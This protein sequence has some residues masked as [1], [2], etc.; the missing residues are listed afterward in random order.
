MEPLRKSS[1]LPP[2]AD[3][4]LLIKA[5]LLLEAI[6]L[7]LLLLP[8]RTS[9]RL[10]TRVAGWPVGPWHAGYHP[11]DRVPWAVELASRCTPGAKSCLTHALAAQ[12]M[13]G[14]RGYPT[15]LHIGVANGE[16]RRFQ[17]HAW[18][19]SKGKVIIGGSEQEP[20]A[21]LAI[22]QAGELKDLGSNSSD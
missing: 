9:M 19:E 20:F 10:L 22:L 11:A 6:K 1:L 18:L 2:S 7:S 8:F 5:A 21:P 13:L 12:V 4:W 16:Q 15:L 14:R 3:W 17:A